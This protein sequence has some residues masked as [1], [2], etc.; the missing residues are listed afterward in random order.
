MRTEKTKIKVVSRN[1]AKAPKKFYVLPT[2]YIYLFRMDL[3]TNSDCFK[4]TEII[5]QSKLR[6]FIVTLL[7]IFT[8]CC[9]P[10]GPLSV[11]HVSRLLRRDLG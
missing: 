10:N 9:V 3:R 7:D 1:L 2:Q 8:E 11:T 6:G 4:D 5:R